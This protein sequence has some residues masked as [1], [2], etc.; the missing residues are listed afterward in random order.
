[1]V[2]KVRIE[3]V[4]NRA[5]FFRI[6]A[7]AVLII[8]HRLTRF[9]MGIGSMP[10]TSDPPASKPGSG[11]ALGSAPDTSLG[12]NPSALPGTLVLLSGGLDSATVLGMAAAGGGD[13]HALSFRYGQRHAFEL[14]AATKLA[15]HYGVLSHRIVDLDLGQFGGSALT[16]DIPVPKGRTTREMS[17]DIP[18]TYVPGRNSIFA[19]IA[20]G[21]AEVIGVGRIALGIN[22]VDYSGYPDCRPA[23][24]SAIQT[25]ADVGTKAGVEGQGPVFWAPL[26]ELTKADIVAKGTALGVPYEVTSTCYAP[27]P[28]GAACGA[29]DACQLRRDGFAAAG[30]P[31]PTRYVGG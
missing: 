14:E 24:L 2:V 5:S 20:L 9:D 12:A 13:L 23:W 3:K 31:D 8:R 26:L 18:V 10:M 15:K 29:C 28:D 17:K 22:A 7:K 11:S 4:L 6:P 16:G 25:V 21:L 30:V 1:M 27:G 19:T